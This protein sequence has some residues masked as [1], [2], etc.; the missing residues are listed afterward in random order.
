M[1]IFNNFEKRKIINLIYNNYVEK[2][3]DC[4]ILLKNGEKI[5]IFTHYENKE[6]TRYLYQNR[7]K[8][9]EFMT[10]NEDVFINFVLK[11]LDLENNFDE[12]YNDCEQCINCKHCYAIPFPTDDWFN[13]D[14]NYRCKI[15]D[16]TIVNC[17]TP[18]K[19]DNCLYQFLRP[20]FCDK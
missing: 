6:M 1:K 7:D 16:L 4:A 8:N 11:K 2:I 5:L 17:I 10:T 15:Y 18:G 20:S 12:Y 9:I 3:N 14:I 13:N 19:D